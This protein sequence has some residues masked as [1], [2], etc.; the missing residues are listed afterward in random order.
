MT[1]EIKPTAPA[2][3]KAKG[4]VCNDLLG[5]VDMN[6]PED[7]AHE[8]GNYS[9]KCVA[10]DKYFVGHK[11]RC[12]CRVCNKQERERWNAMTPEQ[13]K[14]EQ[15]RNTD[16]I[17]AWLNRSLPNVAV[18]QPESNLNHTQA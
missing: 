8:N 11:R 10:C 4:L 14:V 5:S 17:L 6:W 2:D 12:V 7:S 9:N 1:T 13:Q 18:S 3:V 16:E 15:A